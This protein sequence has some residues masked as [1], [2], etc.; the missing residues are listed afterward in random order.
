MNRRSDNKQLMEYTRNQ[1]NHT[2]ALYIMKNIA[3]RVKYLRKHIKRWL[4]NMKKS[5]QK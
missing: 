1:L 3:M 2:V 4:N 5:L